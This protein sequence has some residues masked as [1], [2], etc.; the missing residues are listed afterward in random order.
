MYSANATMRAKFRI[1]FRY[2]RQRNTTFTQLYHPAQKL[3]QR[4]KRL[5]RALNTVHIHR[6]QVF[7]INGGIYF[8]PYLRTKF[9]RILQIICIRTP[10]SYWILF[11][12][13]RMFSHKSSPGNNFEALSRSKCIQ[14]Y[15]SLFHTRGYHKL[16][17]AQPE[18][19][20]HECPATAP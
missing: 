7:H 4:Q 14:F 18:I 13:I 10:W 15:Q 3:E 2:T 19:P 12:T 20:M 8:R 11:R 5:A 17:P 9:L 16:L 6:I 1:H